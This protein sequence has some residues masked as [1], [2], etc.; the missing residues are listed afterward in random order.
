MSRG[1]TCV[2]VQCCCHS[3]I[4]CRD[5]SIVGGRATCDVVACEGWSA[6]SRP[7]RRRQCANPV[8]EAFAAQ[9]SASVLRRVLAAG[10]VCRAESACPDCLRRWFGSAL[11]V[12]VIDQVRLRPDADAHR[13]P[14]GHRRLP[15]RCLAAAV[16][17]L[18]SAGGAGKP[19][20]TQA[21]HVFC[22]AGK[23]L[24]L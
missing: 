12:N 2:T 11:V 19:W 1:D 18:L 3:R 7:V 23:S 14:L 20:P 9:R 8:R 22:K 15:R 24:I 16:I 6:C 4:T 17:T 13:R 10:G 21:T 5:G